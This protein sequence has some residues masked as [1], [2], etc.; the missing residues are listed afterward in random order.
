MQ[1]LTFEQHLLLM[2]ALSRLTSKVRDRVAAGET[3]L[4]D[5]L[6]TLE[7]IERTVAAGTV[8]IEPA[9]RPTAA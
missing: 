3:S 8:H 9:K 2:E 7:T 1:R 4:Q 6:R 5:T